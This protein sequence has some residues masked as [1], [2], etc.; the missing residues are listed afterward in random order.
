MSFWRIYE[1]GK[2]GGIMKVNLFWK[3]WIIGFILL[4]GMGVVE[5]GTWSQSSY[6]EFET[7][8]WSNIDP[9]TSADAVRISGPY[10]SDAN[11]VLLMHMDELSWN[12]TADEVEDSSSYGN[13][14]TAAGNATTTNGKLGRAGE[15]D[16]SDDYIEVDDHA[17]LDITDKVTSEAWVKVT[18]TTGT[19]TVCVK[20]ANIYRLGFSGGSLTPWAQIYLEDN[21]E[22]RLN[23]NHSVTLNQWHHLAMTYDKDGGTNNWK[24]Y[25]DGKLSS[26]TTDSGA[27]K[28]SNWDF[29][30]GAYSPGTSLF[31]GLID[32]VRISNIIRTS[33][34]ESSGYFPSATITSPA[35]NSG[36]SITNVR[37]DWEETLPA[38]TSISYSATN[39]GGISWYELP[40]DNVLF[41]F[42]YSGTDLRVKAELRSGSGTPT[43]HAWS[44]E[45]SGD[46]YGAV[47]DAIT[48]QAIAGAQVILH[49]PDGSI[50]SGTPQD[51]PQITDALGKYNFYADK[52]KYYITAT[53]QGYR[54]FTG[55]IFT[56]DGDAVLVNVSMEPL[57][58][59]DENG[60]LISQSANKTTAKRGDIITY[61]FKIKNTKGPH[62]SDFKILVNLPHN[63]KYIKDS[64]LRDGEKCN[65][66]TGGTQGRLT[67]DIDDIGVDTAVTYSYRVRVGIDAYEGKNINEGIVS[68]ER[69]GSTISTG[70]VYAVV[71]IKSL[72]SPKGLVIGKVFEDTNSNG[73]QDR[74]EC[75]IPYV[76]ILSEYGRVVLTDENGQYT[77]INFNYD[78]HVL[79]IDQR[80]LPGGPLAITGLNPPRDFP[81]DIPPISKVIDIPK[82]GITKANFAITPE[83]RAKYREVNRERIAAWEDPST[84]VRA[85]NDL[86]ETQAQKEILTGYYEKAMAYYRKGKYNEAIS[87]WKKINKAYR[88]RRDSIEPILSKKAK[89]SL[90]QNEFILV[91]LADGELGKLSRFGNVASTEASDKEKLHKELYKNGRV[92][93][94]LKGII[95]GKYLLTARLDTSKNLEDELYESIDPDR[96]YPIYGD[97]SAQIDE[98]DSQEPIY[99]ALTWNKNLIKYGNF[100]TEEFS[101]VEYAKYSRTLP[102]LKIHLE[103]DRAE[104]TSIT[105]HTR[106]VP[107]KDY[108]NPRGLSGPYYLSRN[109][110]IEQSERVYLEIHDKDKDDVVLSTISYE[111]DKDYDMF[112]DDG[113][114]YFSEPIRSEDRYGNPQYI[115]AQY[116]YSPP[117]DPQY[118]TQGVRIKIEPIPETLTLGFSNITQNADDIHLTGADTEI[119]LFNDTTTLSGEYSYSDNNFTNYATKT[120]I[121]STFIPKVNF[122]GHYLNVNDGFSNPTGTL[123]QGVEEYRGKVSYNILKPT[124]IIL[125]SYSRRSILSHMRTIHYG[126]EI[127]NR[128]D[129]LALSSKVTYE[130]QKDEDTMNSLSDMKWTT[131]GGDVSYQLT[132][133][134]TLHSGYEWEKKID[135][136]PLDDSAS[137][138]N[139]FTGRI[140]YQLDKDNLLYLRN[141]YIKVAGTMKNISGVGIEQILDE[142]TS[143]YA[144]Y[145]K[146]GTTLRQNMGYKS[147]VKL[148]KWLSSNVSFERSRVSGATSLDSDASSVSLE[149]KPKDELWLN[150]KI[151]CRHYQKTKEYNLNYESKGEL[152][153]DLTA[154]SKGS[155]SRSKD[156]DTCATTRRDKQGVIGLSYRPVSYD[157]LNVIGKYEYKRK[158]NT[159]IASEESQTQNHIGSVEGAYDLTKNMT[160]GARYAYNKSVEKG[161]DSIDRSHIN[162]FVTSINYRLTPRLD[163]VTEGR[164]IYLHETG[165]WKLGSSIEVGYRPIKDLRLGLGY[166]FTEYDDGDEAHNDQDYL[167]RGPYIKIIVSPAF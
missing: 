111:R 156:Q 75:P 113:Y 24:T 48:G 160:L 153:P 118:I 161:L 3:S 47:Y 139:T 18:G 65:D 69:D 30:V 54:D 17:S 68:Y 110:V 151:E 79:R 19:R 34:P 164:Y 100:T 43:F 144:E 148:T 15:F 104:V 58:Y 131:L 114:I 20:R 78:T 88:E 98:T 46:P 119:K 165:D 31:I 115:I 167:S 49:T 90:H 101:Q 132:K 141:D 107:R 87:E 162:L 40:G 108:I 35:I 133:K 83:Q 16:G 25:F 129:R 74:G 142:K 140:D 61:F 136:F 33:F 91:G 39:D 150:S 77:I 62:P 67:F 56:E 76:A 157:R 73:I 147:K 41:T 38:G 29:Y 127:I 92:A 23:F 72:F 134:I 21:S 123:D 66:P 22:P 103:G 82:S 70:P 80:V 96:Y 105:S 122:S 1:K 163:I 117:L 146:E 102:G 7:C 149:A 130:R 26:Q 4:L 45:F 84:S 124:D 95:Q 138:S 14:G 158:E 97:S 94:Y 120:E 51:N 143:S 166:T 128:W 155:F 125:D 9:L 2:Y 36:E 106:Q 32:E 28:T 121:N 137:Q 159:Q 60:L 116:E 135:E 154:F 99:V 112:Y 10:P 81:K 6:A 12:G 42:P 57:D 44:A 64:S 11:T 5:A 52:G 63:F 8:A 109:P 93:F 71:Y 145:E 85:S 126:G 37:L 86:K 13:H 89:E 27:Q 55:D 59:V 53:C 50:Y 152:T